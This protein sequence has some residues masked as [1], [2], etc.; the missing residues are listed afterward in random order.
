VTQ[1]PFFPPFPPRSRP[2][3]TY[4]HPPTCEGGVV[5]QG[6]GDVEGRNHALG[7]LSNPIVGL[8][9]EREGGREGGRVRGGHDL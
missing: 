1:L 3:S 9:E 8:E 5:R 7:K 6:Q 2:G 4:L